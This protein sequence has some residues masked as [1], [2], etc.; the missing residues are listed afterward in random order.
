MRPIDVLR[1]EGLEYSKVKSYFDR[2]SKAI[3]RERYP[4]SAIFNVDKTGFSLSSTRKLVVLLDKG[5]KRRGKQQARRQE[6]II[7]IEY[8]SAIGVT[9]LPT[10]I[11][12]GQNLNSG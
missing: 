3:Q 5:Y 2:L 8:I 1:F 10:L 7:A 11:F 6:W 12:K 9:L 4:P